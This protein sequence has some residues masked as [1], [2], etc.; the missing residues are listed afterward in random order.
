MTM[1]ISGVVILR[2]S[3]K[4]YK[5]IKEVRKQHHTRLEKMPMT[6]SRQIT[7]I[8]DHVAKHGLLHLKSLHGL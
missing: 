6:L 2:K 3:Q 4:P 7:I 8:N 5:R 1:K